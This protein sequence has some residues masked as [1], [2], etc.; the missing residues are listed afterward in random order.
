MR[1]N[2]TD[3]YLL[4]ERVER[5]ES[6]QVEDGLWQCQEGQQSEEDDDGSD[7]T[8]IGDPGVERVER[9]GTKSEAFGEVGEGEDPEEKEDA[10]GEMFGLTGGDH[11]ENL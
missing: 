8:A 2:S 1:L 10:V 5:D 7:E 4:W 11:G 6:D 9:R 3:I